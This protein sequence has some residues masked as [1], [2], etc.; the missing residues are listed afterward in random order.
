MDLRELFVQAIFVAF[1]LA[2]LRALVSR[3]PGPLGR[4]GAW[5]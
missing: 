1:I 3:L 5:L 2:A 4:L